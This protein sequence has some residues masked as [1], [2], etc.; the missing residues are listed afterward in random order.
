MRNKDGLE[1]GTKI[2]V[3]GVKATVWDLCN[4]NALLIKALMEEG[5]DKGLTFLVPIAQVEKA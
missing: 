1:F 4:N 3:N 2:V 5:H